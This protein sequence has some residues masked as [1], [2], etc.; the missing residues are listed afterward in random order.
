M[1]WEFENWFHIITSNLVQYTCRS[2]VREIYDGQL[3]IKLKKGF[4]F[5][6]MDPW[7]SSY[8]VIR[9]L[10]Q[11]CIRLGLMIVNVLGNAV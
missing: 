5:P 11:F 6:A 7:V 1:N 8:S 3:F 4:N 2:F 9:H 10:I